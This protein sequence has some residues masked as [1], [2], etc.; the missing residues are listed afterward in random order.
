MQNSMDFSVGKKDRR[1][2]IDWNAESIS[3]Q[4]NQSLS[5]RILGPTCLRRTSSLNHN[6]IKL[7]AIKNYR[8]EVYLSFRPCLCLLKIHQD[9]KVRPPEFPIHKS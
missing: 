1:C 8:K 6:I 7:L 3:N 4:N 2:P 5:S 9:W